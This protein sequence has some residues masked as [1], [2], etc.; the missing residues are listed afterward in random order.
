MSPTKEQIERALSEH[1]QVDELIGEAVGEI[2]D[3]LIPPIFRNPDSD[4][5]VVEWLWTRLRTLL[6]NCIFNVAPGEWAEILFGG[7]E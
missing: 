6:A 7:R 3:E 4:Q 5:H 2:S 1:P